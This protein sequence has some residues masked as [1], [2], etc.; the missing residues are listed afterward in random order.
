MK[1]VRKIIYGKCSENKIKHFSLVIKAGIHKML[2]RI[3]YRK[4][5]DQT[6]ILEHSGRVLDSRPR[7]QG[8]ES[9]RRHCVMS[10]SKTH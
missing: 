2:V 9:H 8:F 3:A 6:A 4:D 5:P 1:R 10:L 7:C